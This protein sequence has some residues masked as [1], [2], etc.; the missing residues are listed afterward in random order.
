MDSPIDALDRLATEP[1]AAVFT[2][3]SMPGMNGIAFIRAIRALPAA[4]GKLPVVSVSG[5]VTPEDRA[6]LKDAGCNF[7]VDKPITIHDL[8]QALIGTQLLPIVGL[9]AA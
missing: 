3:V 9:V 5:R 4:Q 8:R 2:D 6:L 1:F 7:C